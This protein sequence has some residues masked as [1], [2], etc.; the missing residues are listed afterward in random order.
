MLNS[1][2]SAINSSTG[3]SESAPRSATKA[4]SFATSASGTPSCSAMIFLTR[5]SISLMTLLR[6]VCVKT[7]GFYLPRT[8]DGRTGLAADA[9]IRSIHVHAAVD[10]QLR[11]GDVAGLARGQERHRLR[12]LLGLAEAAQ[13]DLRQQRGFLRLGQALGHVGLDEARRDAVD[14]DVAAAQLARQRARHARHAGLGR[15]VVGLA[16]VA[17]GA[18]DRGDVDD[19]AEALLHHRAHDLA[20]HAEDRLQVGVVHRVP[21]G[22]LHAHGEVVA[23]DAGVVDQHVHAA[24]FLDDAVDQR[25]HARGVVDVELDTLAAG[26]SGQRLGD[27]LRAGVAGGGADD[28]E[29]TRGELLRDGTADAARGAGDQRGLDVAVVEIA[30]ASTPFIAASEAGSLM[31]PVTSSPSMRLT[32]P[33]SAVP[34]PHSTTCVMPRAF[35]D[36]TTSTQRTAP[37][38][39]RTS[40]SRIAAASTGVATST[41]LTTG[42]EGACS[43]TFSS[44][45][46][47]RSAAGFIRLEWNG[48]DTAS[49]SARLAP[50]ALSISQALS[51]PALVPA[52]TV[53]LGSLKLT[54]STTSPLAS[55]AALQ[56]SRTACAS[57]PR[58]AAIAP[59]PTG[60]A[61]CMACA[62]RRTSGSASASVSTPA[63]TSAVYS[64]SEWP[65]PAAGA[66]PPSARQAR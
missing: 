26:V 31:P 40:A 2:S 56:P 34:G 46:C 43:V 5:A 22:V 48:A 65:A 29:A 66:A 53:C 35:S 42:I 41:L 49:S 8:P 6:E 11:S 21:V 50:A 7:G 59:A 47:R 63:A 14:G 27:R 24:V 54:A 39:W 15:G 44:A 33:A 20:R 55:A 16:G 9:A 61:S 32:M 30:H 64:P 57:R 17:A 58:M 13:R 38:A 60:T 12:D 52:M 18:H 1:S 37:A 62:R 45:A 36:C 10:V 23:R 3:S 51:T 4:L 19:A 28:T 25:R